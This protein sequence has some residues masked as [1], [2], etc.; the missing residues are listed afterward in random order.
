MKPITLIISVAVIA[1]ASVIWDRVD[2]HVVGEELTHNN[3][4]EFVRT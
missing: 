3:K 2:C 4:Y 1:V